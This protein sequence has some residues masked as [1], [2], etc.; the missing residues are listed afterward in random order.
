MQNVP[1]RVAAPLLAGETMLLMLLC[2]AR[3]CAVQA[4]LSNF[5]HLISLGLFCTVTCSDCVVWYCG[6]VL[7]SQSSK[8]RMNWE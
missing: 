2:R 6:A 3:C 1:A 7:H 8:A 4:L 5:W